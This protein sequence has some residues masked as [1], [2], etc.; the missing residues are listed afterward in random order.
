MTIGRT[1]ISK[2][3]WL[4]LGAYAAF[5]FASCAPAVPDDDPNAGAAVELKGEYPRCYS[6]GAGDQYADAIVQ[7]LDDEG[8]VSTSYCDHPDRERCE[9]GKCVPRPAPR[10]DDA[11]QTQDQ[12]CPWLTWLWNFGQC[13]T[14]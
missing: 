9:N 14:P 13:P 6:G 1:T 10:D 7:E 3:R 12:G 2:A 4:A 8:R 11:D 5:L